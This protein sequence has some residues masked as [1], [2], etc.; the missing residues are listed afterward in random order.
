MVGYNDRVT[1]LSAVAL[2]MGSTGDKA[3]L[4]VPPGKWEVIESF[5]NIEGT[6]AHATAGIVKVDVRPVAGQDTNRTDGTAGVLKKTA[7][8]AETGKQIYW[9]P[10]SATVGAAATK[11]YV[12]GGYQLVVEVTTAQGEALG[13]SAGVSLKEV[14]ETYANIATMALT[15]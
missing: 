14:P 1:L 12:Q 7:S 13:F 8:V 11:V 15:A 2:A 3:T 4:V 10:P 9:L 5:I 6:S